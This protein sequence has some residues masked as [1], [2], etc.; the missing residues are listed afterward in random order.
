MSETS[1]PAAVLEGR[2]LKS[3]IS[4]VMFAWR[5]ERGGEGEAVSLL[6]TVCCVQFVVYCVVCSVLWAASHHG[7]SHGIS[8]GQQVMG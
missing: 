6:C 8:H 4:V 7:I 2:S 3:G 1:E 5:C